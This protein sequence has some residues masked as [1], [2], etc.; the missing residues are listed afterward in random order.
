MS[1]SILAYFSYLSNSWVRLMNLR[2]EDSCTLIR[3][4]SKNWSTCTCSIGAPLSLVATRGWEK[5]YFQLIRSASSN[6]KHR[7][8]KFLAFWPILQL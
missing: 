7:S 6:C 5:I 1:S 4:F 3:I 8:I 2:E